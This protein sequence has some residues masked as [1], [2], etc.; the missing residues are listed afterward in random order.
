MDFFGLPSV[1]FIAPGRL[2]LVPCAIAFFLTIGYLA[3]RRLASDRKTTLVREFV[4]RSDLPPFALRAAT[5]CMMFAAAILFAIAYARPEF[6]HKVVTP[7]AGGARIAF[8]VDVSPSMEAEDAT[9]GERTISRVDAMRKYLFAVEAALAADPTF[10]EGYMRTMIPFAG[11][12]L[13]Y[14]NFTRSATQMHEF[15]S[16]ITTKGMINKQGSDLVKAAKEYSKILDEYPRPDNAVD[17]A[18]VIS[19]GGNDPGGNEL[20][21]AA[22]AEEMA[23]LRPRATVISVGL[24]NDEP[25]EIPIRGP[26]G[27]KTGVFMRDDGIT[28]WTTA[29][30][31]SIMLSLADTSKHC[32]RLSLA[33][34]SKTCTRA[35]SVDALVTKTVALI[36]AKRIPLP[37]KVEMKRAPAEEYALFAGLV[38]VFIAIMCERSYAIT[39]RRQKERPMRESFFDDTA[40]R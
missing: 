22:L 34:D 2:I 40:D 37:P 26:D 13:S 33:R 17:I 9:D 32:V 8:V 36:Q 7:A 14:G 38:L 12:P 15:L 3:W 4:R 35:Q 25:A 23:R 19:D 31:E 20:D 11:H 5:F 16:A 24:G 29:F 39:R 6:V 1:S 21:V 27:S 18:I 28:P 10:G 30:D